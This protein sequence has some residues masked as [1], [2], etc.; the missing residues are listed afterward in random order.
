[1]VKNSFVIDTSV[2]A[3]AFYENERRAL[4]RAI[5]NAAINEKVRLAAPSLIL[6]EILSVFAK[7][8]GGEQAAWNA[9]QEFL[10]IKDAGYINVSE[11]SA[12]LF[13]QAARIAHLPGTNGHISPFD[14]AFHALAINLDYTFL[15][16]DKRHYNKTK[17]RLGHI[18]LLDDFVLPQ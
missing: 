3:L 9:F 8:K 10:I 18:L 4:S 11:S 12:T 5:I 2:A 16:A 14:A 13:E 1:M 6:Y 7:V 17:D 15:T